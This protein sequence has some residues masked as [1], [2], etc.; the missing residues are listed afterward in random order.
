MTTV[1]EVRPS[2]ETQSLGSASPRVRPYP[3]PYRAMFAI[4]SDLDETPDA[5]VYREIM[6]FLNTTHTTSMG[7]GVGLEV[8]NTLYFDMPPD[9]YAYWNT[10]DAGRD[11]ARA[12]IRSGHIDCLHS[13]GDFATT[14]AHA[15]RALE[16]LAKHDC[17]LEVWID[18]AVAP[19]NFGADIMRGLG[20]VPG[21]D[22]YHAD[23]TC[24]YGIKYVWRGRVTSAIGQNVPRDLGGIF[25]SA[26][27]WSSSVTLG[28]EWL[29]SV[30]ARHGNVKYAMHG[31]N[32]VVC[33][34]RLR[35]DRPVIE[36]LRSNPYWGGPGESA[37]A[38]GFA[39][40]VTPR[41]LDCLV[42]RQGF[43]VFYTHLGKVHSYEEPFAPATRDALR[44]LAT[45]HHD[46]RILVTTTRRLLGFARAVREVSVSGIEDN[47]G[48]RIDVTTRNSSNQTG[49]ELAEADLNGLTF[50]VSDPKTTRLFLDGQEVPDIRRNDPD[51]TGQRSVSLP[52]H[53]PLEFPDV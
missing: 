35:N 8:G 13:F 11:M 2:P 6:R 29:K 52:W 3:F 18:H 1:C 32:E 10:D 21:S 37:T 48:L 36:F 42:E 26:H 49:I 4:C 7:P 44:R 30:L 16:E 41:M 47:F 27:P 24:D 12:L 40:V 25:R 38:D 15:A 22:V 17:R 46:G 19:S 45:F 34:E 53:R 33:T 23:L 31:S 9:Q 5:H 39:Q 28:K 50:Y 20:D 43:C 14:R 51:E